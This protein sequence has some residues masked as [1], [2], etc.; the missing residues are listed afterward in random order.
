M[1]HSLIILT[2]CL[3]LYL[4]YVVKDGVPKSL[5]ATYY[6]LGKAGWLF[7]L[8]MLLLSFGLFPIWSELSD[9]SWEFLCFLGCGG[10]LLVGASPLFKLPLESEVHHYSAYVCGGSAVLW[11]LLEGAWVWLVLCFAL[12]AL[13]YLKWRKFMWWL[14][15]ALMMSLLGNLFLALL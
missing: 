14:E 6:Q 1:E 8:L 4:A 3:V 12:C 9:D 5:S 15:V 7:Q 13:A 2:V 10:L 11:Q